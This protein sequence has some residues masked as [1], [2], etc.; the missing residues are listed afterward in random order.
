MT[1]DETGD[2][3]PHRD[4]AA[5]AS[6]YRQAFLATD[7]PA[8]VTDEEFTIVDINDACLRIGDW[9]RDELVG[10]YPYALFEEPDLFQ[11][12]VESLEESNRWRG[13]FE[14]R[15]NDGRHVSGE[16]SVEPLV[17]DGEVTGYVAIFVDHTSRRRQQESLRV[18][19]RVLRHNLRNDANVVLGHLESAAE[20]VADEDVQQSL[21]V[22]TRRVEAILDRANTT[23]E[24][25]RLLVESEDPT[26][27]PVTVEGAVRQ[28][29]NTVD[30]RT[31]TV[32]VD[33]P[34]N[35]YVLA[36]ETVT[37]AIR[38]V[39]E[40]AVEHGSTGREGRSP[41]GTRAEPGDSQT[42]SGDAV[43]HAGPEVTVRVSVSAD[44]Q[45]VRIHVAD[46]GPGISPERRNQVLE[47][48]STDVYHGQG[49]GLFFVDRLMDVYGGDLDIDESEAGGCLVTLSFPRVRP[50]EQEFET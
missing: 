18:L 34:E 49:L 33:V 32:S 48:G 17:V 20:R 9:E 41:S 22:A 31:A 36:D 21:A 50:E 13:E 7:D 5:E 12:I 6:R 45:R 10:D 1:V 28:A 2:D 16:G 14:A 30:T 26:F 24:F 11:R 8:I 42:Q 15:T 38:N 27:Y 47:R 44:E 43:D 19:N 29:V 4:E 35:V 3:E 46:D 40:N 23:R 37:A 39:V 25:S